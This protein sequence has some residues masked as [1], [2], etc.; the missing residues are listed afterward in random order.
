VI[1]GYHNGQK[2]G[3]PTANLQPDI[4]NRLLPPVG[5]YVV[6]AT[7]DGHAY[8]GMLNIG[9]RPTI[10][11]DGHLTLE[12]HLLNFQ[13]EIYGEFVKIDFVHRLRDEVKFS[14]PQQ[15]VEQLERDVQSVD[16]YL[17]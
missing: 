10:S 7:L 8:K 14:S 6:W 17:R 16:I 5:V 12:V 13:G 11:F 4:P 9:Y 1:P 15:L 3:F 2:L